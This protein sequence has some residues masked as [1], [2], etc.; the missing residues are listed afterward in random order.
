MSHVAEFAVAPPEPVEPSRISRRRAALVVV[1]GLA[2]AGVLVGALWAWLAPPIGVVVGLSKSGERVRG[3]VGNE[4]DHLFLAAFLV[5]GFLTVVTVVAAVLVWQ[6]RAHRGPLMAGALT[7]GSVLAAGLAAG[8]GAG[9]AWLRYGVVDIASA[10]VSPEHRVHYAVEAGSVF[11]GHS[12]LQIAVTIVF[13]A[14]VAAL[15]YAL[16]TLATTRDD[17][18]AWP[19]AE[20]TVR[21]PARPVADPVSP[22]PTAT[23]P[24]QTGVDV[25]P[26]D[27]SSPSR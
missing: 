10:P 23:D 9:L 27:P 7:V 22:V 24:A 6:W 14:G 8:I 12:P 15:V 21:Y 25:P 26:V 17:L 16:C 4:A 11:F 19:P 3:Y 13:P 2:L 1:S 20:P 5:P 18:G